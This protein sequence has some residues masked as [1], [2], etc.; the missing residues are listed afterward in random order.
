MTTTVSRQAVVA[1]WAAQLGC[2]EAQLAQPHTS[3]VRAGPELAS[4]RGATVVFRPPACVLAV[5]ADWYAP[6]A[7][8]IGH[9]PPAEVFDV[10]VQGVPSTRRSIEEGEMVVIG[11]MNNAGTVLL[12]VADMSTIEAEV[13]VDAGGMFAPA[14]ARLAS[15]TVPIVPIAHEYLFTNEIQ[16][17]RS[18]AA[19]PGSSRRPPLERRV[20]R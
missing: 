12:T 1:F 7:S 4:Y 2:S 15:V 13:V 18:G 9:R 8:R 10:I 14:I 6:V 11:T 3:V 19:A 5:P 16:G 20:R 17:V